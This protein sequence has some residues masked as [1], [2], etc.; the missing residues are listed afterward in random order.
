M[1]EA[2]VR[3]P[4][5]ALTV[6]KEP[7]FVLRV[8]QGPD[9][10]ASFV[11]EGTQAP[12]VLLGTSPTCDL[13]LTDRR[14]SRRHLCLELGGGVVRLT[15]LSSTNG[16]TVRGVLVREAFLRGGETLE[17][18]D[19]VISVSVDADAAKPFLSE[20][21]GFGRLVGHSVAMRRL[22]PAMAKLAASDMPVVIEGETG[23]GK[24]LLAECLHEAGPR[25]EGPFVVFDCAA[26]RPERGDGPLRAALLEATSG[27]LVLD[28]IAE[29][30]PALQPTLL[31]AIDRGEIARDGGSVERLD[32]RFLATTRRDLD[33]EAEAGRLRDDLYFR[34]A[35]ARI[36]LPP[37]RRRPEDVRV[38]ALHFWERLGGA[39]EGMPASAL[40]R[41][42]AYR[43]PGNVRELMNA[44]SRI[45]TLGEREPDAAAAAPPH[46]AP[47][48]ASAGHDFLDLVI[49]DG[50]PLTRAR[51]RVVEEFERRY[52]EAAFEQNGRNVTKAAAA[53][54]IARRYFR[55]LR[56]RHR[57]GDA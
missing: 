43:Y 52:V 5:R 10:G 46:G 25:A 21:T 4:K 27:T 51:E 33:R 55:A 45:V 28:E 6:A 50:L 31:R 16:T 30:D 57:G 19:S 48:E 40:A 34:L 47:H 9:A 35:V 36:E 23:T 2:T 56:A 37:L 53:S 29:L 20:E 11:L 15:D 32:V 24:E 38:L 22:Y 8:T 13:R 39:S 44:V 14:V 42:E 12:R 3:A 41:L 1:S 26:A 7:A 54:G 18:G 17:I 49:A